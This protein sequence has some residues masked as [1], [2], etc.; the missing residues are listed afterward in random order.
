M[1]SSLWTHPQG[2]QGCQKNFKDQRINNLMCFCD[3]I[4]PNLNKLRKIVTKQSLLIDFLDFMKFVQSGL[5]ISAKTHLY[6]SLCPSG[7][8]DN[9]GTPVVWGRVHIDL[10]KNRV[11]TGCVLRLLRAA[12]LQCYLWL[13][14]RDIDIQCK[15]L[16]RP[17]ENNNLHH[18]NRIQL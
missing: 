8:F 14:C 10:N 2:C 7:S 11:R 12:A 16:C 13:M 6:W 4:Q 9:P 17:Q 15:H 5:S 3:N 18:Q 1:I